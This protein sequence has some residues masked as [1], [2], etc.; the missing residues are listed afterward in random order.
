[1][2]GRD[3]E[4]GRY[5]GRTASQPGLQGVQI[6]IGGLRVVVGMLVAAGSAAAVGVFCAVAAVDVGL[7]EFRRGE[8]RMG[9]RIGQIGAADDVR[10]G[11]R[12][13]VSIVVGISI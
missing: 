7:G 3:D 4:P 12:I 11:H 2:G 8:P 10:L 1:M 5:Q 6:L 13:V 9:G